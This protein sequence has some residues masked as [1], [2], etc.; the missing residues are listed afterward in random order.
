MLTATNQ[1]P[2]KNIKCHKNGNVNHTIIDIQAKLLWLT[3]PFYD[4]CV[5]RS[6][7]VD[8]VYILQFFYIHLD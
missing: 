6:V 5:F 1:K 2:Q 7:A 8:S 4:F 3:L